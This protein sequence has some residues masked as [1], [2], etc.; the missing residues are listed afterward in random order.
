ML[1]KA[2]SLAWH[3]HPTPWQAQTLVTSIKAD[4]E[5]QQLAV[6]VRLVLF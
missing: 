1:T 2:M 4:R 5:K 6:H 3:Q